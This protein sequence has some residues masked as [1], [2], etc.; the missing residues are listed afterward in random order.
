MQTHLQKQW[1]KP[2]HR[3][4]QRKYI[5]K[6]KWEK[7]YVSSLDLTVRAYNLLLCDGIMYVS[8]IPFNEKGEVWLK[9]L[10]TQ[11]RKSKSAMEIQ[12]LLESIGYNFEE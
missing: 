6:K 9:S 1:S 10:K 5:Q 2:F 11:N 8:Q 4:Q 3:L 12:E 7:V